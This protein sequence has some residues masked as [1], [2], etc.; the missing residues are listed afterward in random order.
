MINLDSFKIIPDFLD[1][2]ARL[3]PNKVGLI[4]KDKKYTYKMIKELVNDVSCQLTNK[5]KKGDVIA[6][7]SPNIPEMIFSYFGILGAGCIV[8]LLSANIS[9]ENLILQIKK[10][11]PKFIFSHRKYKSK[12]DRTEIIKK[13]GFFDIEDIPSIKEDA[14][15]KNVKENDIST[16][17]FTSG[18]TNEPKGAILRHYNVVNATKNIIEF[19]KWEPNDIDVNILSL[20]HSFGLGNI[21]CVFAAG[22]TVILFN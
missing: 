2:S 5:T 22:G 15:N 12:L 4:F 8:L 20:S 17:I 1:N 10:A 16:L 13:V 14:S 6:L 3:F 19:L 7:L 18:T 9:D 21:H 11:K